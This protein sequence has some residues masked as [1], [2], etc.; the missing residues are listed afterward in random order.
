MIGPEAR[1][2]GHCALKAKPQHARSIQQHE[3]QS[4][5]G[6][7]KAVAQD[8]NGPARRCATGFGMEHVTWA[9]PKIEPGNGRRQQ[10]AQDD[11]CGK[12]H[13]RYSRVE[14]NAGAKRQPSSTQRSHQPYSAGPDGE[15]EQPSCQRE[16]R[17]FN[18]NFRHDKPSARAQRLPDGCLFRPGT[19][20]DEKE[21]HQVDHADQQ[22]QEHSRLEQQQGGSHRRH[23]VGM[24]RYD[25]RTKSGVGHLF[26][27]WVVLLEGR[28]LRVNF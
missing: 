19:G 25:H 22:Q 8:L 18:H 1:R 23:L 2:D 24:K 14:S 6:D 13:R 4:Y 5:L 20:S 3:C 17:G 7:H 10:D 15:T 21:I 9:Q 28:I 26:A 16:Q 12:S 27:L 11:G